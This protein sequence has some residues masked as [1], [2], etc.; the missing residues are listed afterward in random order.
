MKRLAI[1]SIII[2]VLIGTVG[3]SGL[4][5]SPLLKGIVVTGMM[6]TAATM[7]FDKVLYE[8]LKNYDWFMVDSTQYMPESYTKLKKFRQMENAIG[9][10]STYNYNR[11]NSLRVPLPIPTTRIEF[12]KLKKLYPNR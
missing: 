5:G 6:S 10:I 3:C 11:L 8:N 2:G 1:L 4:Y 12:Q 7:T 9:C